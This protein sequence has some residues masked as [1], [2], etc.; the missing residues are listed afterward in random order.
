M[1]VLLVSVAAGSIV[2]DLM[3]PYKSG[4]TLR[5]RDFAQWFWFDLAHDSE[6]VCLHTDCKADLAPRTFL[7]GWSALY[8]CNQRIYSPRHARGRA[9]RTWSAFRRSVRCGACCFA[10]WSKT[11]TTSPWTAGWRKCSARYKLIARD[12]YPVPIYGKWDGPPESIQNL[13][14]VFKFVP[15]AAAEKGA[16][17]VAEGVRKGSRKGRSR[18]GFPFS[19]VRLN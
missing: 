18:G 9:L 15:A 17:R 8:L 16:G 14:E 1:L 13:I 5:S 4:L 12:S 11:R 2:H 19:A 7:G 3:H 6:L 10:T